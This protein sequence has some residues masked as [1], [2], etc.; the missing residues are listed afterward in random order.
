LAIGSAL[1]VVLVGAYFA[2]AALTGSQPNLRSV[3][4]LGILFGV[5]IPI[6]FGVALFLRSKCQ[7]LRHGDAQH[8]EPREHD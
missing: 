8:A 7:L 2:S 4:F 6:E 5:W 3:V 1:A